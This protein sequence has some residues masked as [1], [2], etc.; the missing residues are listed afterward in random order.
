MRIALGVSYNG[1]NYHGWQSQLDGLTIQDKLE[2]ALSQIAGQRTATHCAGRTDSGVHAL[3]QVVHFDTDVVRPEMAWVRGVNAVLPKDIAVHWARQVPESFHCRSSATSRRYS[4][5]LLQSPV[6][7]SIEFGRVGWCFSALDLEAMQQAV[8]CLLGEHD[9]SSFRASACQSLTPVK[10]LTAIDIAHTP[11][12]YA[13]PPSSEEN[14]GI[15]TGYWRF[16]FEANAFLHHMIRNLMG[17]LIAIGQGSKPPEWMKEVLEA[18]SR[19]VAAPTFAPDGLYF[20]G[21]Q[22]DPQ[23]GL[24]ASNALFASLPLT[25]A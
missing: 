16:D 3:Q 9:F 23:W 5:I 25:R 14:K 4:Y 17:C 15:G 12:Q 13:H 20:L 21:P 6:R 24:P 2:K 10:T 18:R 8:Q 11:L 22:Y 1:Q 7:P 19:A